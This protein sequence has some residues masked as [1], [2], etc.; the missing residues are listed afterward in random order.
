M[1]CEMCGNANAVAVARVEGVDMSV[2]ARCA[3]HG[4]VRREIEQPQ[5]K[6]KGAPRKAATQAQRGDEL[7]ESVH[8]DIARMLHAHR[9]RLS[10]TQEDFAKRLNIRSSVYQ[11]YEAGTTVPDIALARR[12]E[13]ELHVPLVVHI[14]LAKGPVSTGEEAA[15]M[16]LADFVKK[17]GKK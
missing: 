3:G 1:E 4:V 9:E 12:L 17:K 8:P 6:P 2:C 13:H 14:K 10:L 5:K 11:H 7:V 15:G 16:T